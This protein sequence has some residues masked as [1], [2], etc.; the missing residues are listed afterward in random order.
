MASKVKIRKD[1][2]IS[3]RIPQQD[4]DHICSESENMDISSSEFIRIAIEKS[5][6]EPGDN[7]PTES[8]VI[9]YL[10]KLT[11]AQ[12]DGIL[13]K[14]ENTMKRRLRSFITEVISRKP[15]IKAKALCEMVSK[16]FDLPVTL[17]LKHKVY[18]RIKSLRRRRKLVEQLEKEY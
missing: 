10:K 16:E 12:R 7:N 3:F 8:E 11:A 14:A 1:K 18:L 9:S 17:D 4:Y 6:R 5:R 15:G 13:D 2:L